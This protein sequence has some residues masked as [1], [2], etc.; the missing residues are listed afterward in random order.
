MRGVNSLFLLGT[1]R[2]ESDQL[3]SKSGKNYIRFELDVVTVRR[4]DGMEEEQSEVIPITA[5]GKL[6][7]IVVKHVKPG[8]PL[9]VTGRI[10]S[11]EFKTEA[12]AT[13]RTVSVIA[14]AIQLI[15]TNGRKLETADH[16]D[17]RASRA[18]QPTYQIENR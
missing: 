17:A 7:E 2:A 9:Q 14:D 15:S 4:K 12:G 3:T 5:F 8:D 18:S 10:T 16:S 6:G 11:T 13:R 1:L